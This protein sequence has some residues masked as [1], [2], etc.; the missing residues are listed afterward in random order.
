MKV[1]KHCVTVEQLNEFCEIKPKKAERLIEELSENIDFLP[2]GYEEETFAEQLT[3]G[4]LI[5]MIHKIECDIIIESAGKQWYVEL[6]GDLI[7]DSEH[8]VDALWEMV[9]MVI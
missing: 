8:L 6:N 3:I 7:T 9:M 5:E 4:K 1:I 2:L